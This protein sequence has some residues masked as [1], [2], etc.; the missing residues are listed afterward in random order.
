MR[1]NFVEAEPLLDEMLEGVAIVPDPVGLPH[2]T[3]R[4]IH[5]DVRDLRT[6]LWLRDKV[7]EVNTGFSVAG[8]ISNL[9]AM[10]SADPGNL[11]TTQT[12]PPN[13]SG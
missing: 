4:D 8:V 10:A 13:I 7:L 9:R 5:H 6:I 12:S 3:R 1:A 2:V 11:A